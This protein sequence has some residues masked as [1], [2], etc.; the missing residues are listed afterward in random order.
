M[1]ASVRNKYEFYFECIGKTLKGLVE[2]HEVILFLFQK[3]L[4]QF[5]CGYRLED[6]GRMLEAQYEG[7]HRKEMRV[8]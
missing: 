3:E 6:Q 7:F 5:M 2:G 4:F 8:G 1:E